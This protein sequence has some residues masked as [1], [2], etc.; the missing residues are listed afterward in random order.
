[1]NPPS[2]CDW[3]AVITNLGFPIVVAGYLL[4]RLDSVIT[5]LRDSV[6]DI[7]GAVG[8]L[9]DSITDLSQHRPP[10]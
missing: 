7:P 10:M 1:M 9:A 4:I 5:E 3:V 2:S 8:R 6:R